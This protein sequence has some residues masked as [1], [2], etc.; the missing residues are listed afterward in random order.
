MRGS[1]VRL[2][3]PMS[4]AQDPSTQLRGVPIR[5]NTGHDADPEKARRMPRAWAKT[6][7]RNRRR[8]QDKREVSR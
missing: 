5:T 3:A 8:E 7:A 1:F 2:A 4:R 6:F